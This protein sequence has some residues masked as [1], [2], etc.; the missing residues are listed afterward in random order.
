MTAIPAG[1]HAFGPPDGQLLVK[2]FKEGMAARMGHDL[3][4]EVKSWSAEATMDPSDL[5]R[6]Q[7]EA[8]AE[9]P[10]FSIIEA[11]G[12]AKP[13]GR[14]DRSDIKKNIE[15]KVL[16]TARFPSISFRSTGV[17]SADGTRGTI[18]GELTIAGTTQPA[19]IQVAVNGDRLKATLTVVQSKWGIKPFSAL[20][21][22][23]KVRDTVEVELEVPVPAAG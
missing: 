20:M 15:E 10:S 18:S 16:N 21:G 8:S 19:D 14:S 9:V 5:S 22:A 2:V 11:T 1:T 17:N 23:L 13:L 3:V 4:F 6:T 7:I 12:G